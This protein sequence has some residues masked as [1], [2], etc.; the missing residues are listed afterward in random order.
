MHS[1]T[2]DL[3]T[4]RDAEPLDAARRAELESEPA[5]AAEI[6]RLERVR[7]ALRELPELGPPSGVLERIR[8]AEL[9]ARS[10]RA[11]WVG[12]GARAGLAAAVAAAAVIYLARL[13]SGPETSSTGV[14]TTVAPATQPDQ[15]TAPLV[16]A[17]YVALVEESARLERVLA[18]LPS[19]RPLMSGL[20]A[21]TI[22]GL[23][24]RIAVIDEQ[25]TLGTARGLEMPQREALWGERVEL[26]NALVHVRYAQARW[27]GF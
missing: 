5:S 13:P 2:E 17:S 15:L 18:R 20:T 3:L 1:R 22:V 27:T 24:D 8:A 10:R 9:E 23:E 7:D 12:F 26:M 21:S 16:P 11:A 25:L 4:I 6:D 19:Q 14:A